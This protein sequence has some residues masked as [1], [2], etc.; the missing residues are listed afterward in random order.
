MKIRFF[1]IVATF[2]L[3]TSCKKDYVCQCYYFT[4]PNNPINSETIHDTQKKAKSKC[5]KKY[6]YSLEVSCKLK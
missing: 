5:E 4:D 3:L 1:S 6:E 2:S